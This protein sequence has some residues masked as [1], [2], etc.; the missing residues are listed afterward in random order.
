VHP[1]GA[2][3][4]AKQGHHTYTSP[5]ARRLF[6]DVLRAW[7]DPTRAWSIPTT[8]TADDD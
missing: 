2:A 8:T 6:I 7:A 5:L 1:Q 3:A 4:T